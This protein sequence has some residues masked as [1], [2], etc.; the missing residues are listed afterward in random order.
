MNT[1]NIE[2]S[3]FQTFLAIFQIGEKWSKSECEICGCEKDSS[4]AAVT[5]CEELGKEAWHP[6]GDLCEKCK[7]V[8]GSDGTIS[9]QCEK[10]TCSKCNDVS[11]LATLFLHIK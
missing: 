10:Q 11:K 9:K 5:K 1:F 3:G 7:C 8:V 6:D 2:K 4:G